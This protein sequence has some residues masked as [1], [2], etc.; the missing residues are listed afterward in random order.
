MDNFYLAIII[1]ACGELAVGAIKV[2]GKKLKECFKDKFTP[3]ED[4]IYE[5][6]LFGAPL[7]P[8]EDDELTQA[9]KRLQNSDE[10]IKDL[11]E[12]IF[13]LANKDGVTINNQGAKIEQQINVTGENAVLNFQAPP[14]NADKK[15]VL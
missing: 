10:T 9:I 13:S 14:A 6:A 15:K 12:K 11:I 8:E 7:E 5:K 4:A 3:G 1:E 2:A